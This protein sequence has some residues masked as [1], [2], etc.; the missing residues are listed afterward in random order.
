[1]RR[2][3]EIFYFK[4][5]GYNKKLG[6]WGEQLAARFLIKKGFELVETN[7]Y[8]REG[9]IDLI[10]KFQDQIVFVEVKTRRSIKFGFGEDAVSFSKRLKLKQAIEKYM[11]DKEINLC[12]RFDLVVVE[13]DKLTPKF[14]H[15]EAVSLE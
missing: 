13:I 15:F 11:M 1:L 6:Q 9:E 12:P 4:M 7:Y 5:K 14:I 8:C 3:L 10:F 2:H